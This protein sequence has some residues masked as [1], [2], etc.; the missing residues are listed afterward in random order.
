[1]LVWKKKYL[2]LYARRNELGAIRYGLSPWNSVAKWR[3]F[4]LNKA[5]VW[6][7]WLVCEQAL[8]SALAAGPEK[9]GELAPVATKSLEFEFHHQFACGS[10][11]TEL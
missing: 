3:I 6:R 4:L 8:R 11:S 2:T 1:M 5:K 10:P 7:P 9:E